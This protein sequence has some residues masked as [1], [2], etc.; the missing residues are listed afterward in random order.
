MID[1]DPTDE[2]S[3]LGKPGLLFTVWLLLTVFIEGL[4]IVL[5]FMF[6]NPISSHPQSLY[7]L[8]DQVGQSWRTKRR[9]WYAAAVDKGSYFM[10]PLTPRS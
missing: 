1:D 8:V 6:K 10:K 3:D 7:L 4:L 5:V 9:Q 2:E